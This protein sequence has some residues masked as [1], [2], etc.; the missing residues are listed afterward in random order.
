MYSVILGK[1]VA[2]MLIMLMIG[3]FLYKIK[4]AEEN[5]KKLLTYILLYVITPCLIFNTYQMEYNEQMAK[6]LAWAFLLSFVA[7]FIAVILS[8]VMR[9]GSK[10]MKTERFSVIFTN[11]GFMGIPLADAAFGKEGVFYCTIFVTAFNIVCWTYGRALMEGKTGTKKSVKEIIK[12]FCNVIILSIILGVVCYFTPFRVTGTVP[13]R[14]I[15]FIADMNTPLAMITS[16]IYV[17]QSDI[18]SALKEKRVYLQLFMKCFVVPLVVLLAFSWIPLDMVM[19]LAIVICMA[20]PTGSNVIFFSQRFGGDE[21]LGSYFF[22]T[23]TLF[24]VV[25]IPII[26]LVAQY[27]MK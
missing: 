8:N 26:M 12:P 1:Q 7:I 11:C 4:V 2:T 15:E 22:T 21:K 3:F 14:A 24:S 27:L 9:I 18:L 23:T 25:S 13:G 10:S 17:A 20:A 16:G 6:N 19:K 5:G